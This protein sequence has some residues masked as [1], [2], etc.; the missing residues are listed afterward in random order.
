MSTTS[1]NDQTI[2]TCN[3]TS[4]PILKKPVEKLLATGFT[5]ITNYCREKVELDVESIYYS[6]LE[7]IPTNQPTKKYALVIADTHNNIRYIQTIIEVANRLGIQ[8]MFHAGDV[9]NQ[10]SL[11][12]FQHFR[13]KFSLSFGNHDKAFTGKK[14]LNR[15]CNKYKFN[16]RCDYVRL[17]NNKKSIILTHGNDTKL[18][19]DLIYDHNFDFLIVGHYHRRLLLHNESTNKYVINP[20]AFNDNPLPSNQADNIPSFVLLPLS[21][22]KPSDIIFY[23][24]V[25]K[26]KKRKQ[27]YIQKEEENHHQTEQIIF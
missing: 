11:L 5:R 2:N 17:T 4:Y 20:G 27:K 26:T 14:E 24:I 15:I 12:E 25:D 10:H 9:V 3:V 1:V 6:I 22:N 16:H 19:E 7:N 23:H 18:L 21:V 13:G 8:N